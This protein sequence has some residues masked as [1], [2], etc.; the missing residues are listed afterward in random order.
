MRGEYTAKLQGLQEA[1]QKA[2][3]AH[4]NFVEK[5]ENMIEALE[6]SKAAHEAKLAETEALEEQHRNDTT[7]GESAL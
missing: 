5:T 2:A 7:G 4:V 6:K 3:V 1:E